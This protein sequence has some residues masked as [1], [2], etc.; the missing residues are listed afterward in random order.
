MSLNYKPDGEVLNAFMRSNA[1][2]RGIRGP[3]GS[4]KSVACCVDLFKRGVEQRRDR[5]GK[6]RTRFG[7]IRNTNPQLKTTTIK[8]WLDWFPEDVWGRF[9]WSVPYTHHIIKDDLD[10]EVLFLA[11]DRPE[12]VKK[13]LSLELTAIWV[14][15]AREI[16]KSIIDA[17]T[18]RVMRY[19]AKKDGGATWSGIICD[20]N[21]PE[22]DHWW[23]IM[24]GESP[25]P[26]Y[27]TEDDRL[28]LVKPEGWEFY[29]QPSGMLELKKDDSIVGYGVN[30]RRENAK[31]IDSRYYRT[32]I[33]GKSK[34]WIDVYV[35]N[36]LGSTHDG[37]PV[38]FSYN[39]EVHTSRYPL[40][41]ASNVPVWIG[42]D[43]GLTP[44]A[45]FAQRMPSGQWHVL[46]EIVTSDMGIK[47]FSQ[48]LKKS[49][50]EWC[51]YSTIYMYGD[52]A[53]DIRSQ[54]DEQTPFRILR[55]NGVQAVP[56]PSN[57]PVIRVESVTQILDRMIDGKPGLLL[58][59]S[60]TMIRRGFQSGYHYKRLSVG[61]V[62]RY[63]EKPD[64]NKYSHVHDAFQYLCL[65]AGEARILITRPQDQKQN[66][67]PRSTYSVFDR[68]NRT[69][70]RPP[71]GYNS[72]IFE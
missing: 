40:D 30:S 24:S 36:R 33:G 28:T 58:D 69:T 60:C 4:G 52:P 26:E 59:P 54:T 68:Q 32:I 2:F 8:T 71:R 14:N 42:L 46:R 1:F 64:K 16:P 3:V 19:P 27:M 49:I 21:A 22:D 39:D 62:A 43:F 63:D 10:M 47:R 9:K 67:V 55:A 35:M 17:C 37:K 13:L 45:V 65:G 48:I 15:E 72:R 66:L 34:H 61:G 57:D 23:P 70:K 50:A 12:D 51:P 25:M 41:F 38:Y 7:V 20:T 18:M 44:A 6:R 53:G 56:A 11:L 31:F 5:T 29:T